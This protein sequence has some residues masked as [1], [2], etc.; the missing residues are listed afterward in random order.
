MKAGIY[1]VTLTA[2]SSGCNT[3]KTA[4]ITVPEVGSVSFTQTA[5]PYCQ[6]EPIYFTS[7]SKGNI[8][9]YHW[10]LG[11][12]KVIAQNTAATFEG[13][14]PYDLPLN[15]TVT[16]TAQD[17][18]GCNSVSSSMF[19]V[20]GNTLNNDILNPLTIQKSSLLPFCEGDSVQ[21]LSSGPVTT[22]NPPISYLWSTL[23][24]TPSIW[25]K[26][27]GNYGV[28]IRDAVNSRAYLPPI[29][30]QAYPVF[31]P[32]IYGATT[33]CAD[34][35]EKL[36]TFENPTISYTWIV[37][38]FAS[39][40]GS[41]YADY[42][43]SGSHSI[44]VEA[45]DNYTGCIDTSEVFT[46]TVRPVL[47]S[48][49]ISASAAVPYCEG[50]AITFTGYSAD[51]IAYNWNGGQSDASI[52]V[53]K[54][55]N[56]VLTITDTAGCHSKDSVTI[57]PLPDF[58]DFLFG[59]YCFPTDETNAPLL[60]GPTAN[61]YE[62]YVNGAVASTAQNFQA[63]L[64]I[65]QLVATTDA[66]CT[67]TSKV[68]EVSSYPC[69][70]CSLSLGK[71]EL[72]CE[73][74]AANGDF[75][76]HFQMDATYSGTSLT[77]YFVTPLING[78]PGGTITQTNLIGLV[79]G[80]KP[81]TGSLVI[82]Q[83]DASADVCFVVTALDAN[84][85]ICYDTI[86]A[87][88]PPAI[89]NITPD[90]TYVYD[91]QTCIT[92]FTNTSTSN[93]CTAMDSTK[94]TWNFI[95]NGVTTN[96]Q[97][98]TISLPNL[99]GSYKV[100]LNTIGYNYDNTTDCHPSLCKNVSIEA[101][102]CICTECE[103]EVTNEVFAGRTGNGCEMNI[104]F[105]I[106]NM[107]AD[108]NFIRAVSSSG[109]ISGFN[110]TFVN[111]GMGSYTLN[112]LPFNQNSSQTVCIKLFFEVDGSD[113]C[114][115]EFCVEIPPCDPDGEGR[116]SNPNPEMTEKVS[117]LDFS[118]VPNPANT[119]VNVLWQPFDQTDVITITIYS[120]QF[121]LI[122]SKQVD[123]NSGR[124]ALNVSNWSNGMYLV[125]LESKNKRMSKR[126]LVIHNH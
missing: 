108:A 78:V 65:I 54:P 63:Q 122:Y 70:S 62:W 82:N 39:T 97:G 116:K 94:T 89:C 2:S 16:L 98:N 112:I 67:D 103:M 42:L 95:R 3:K 1:T 101:V 124:L 28:K 120:S 8:V 109:Q 125:Q 114:C 79:N 121:E 25:A 86:C 100:C 44:Q 90:F 74:K 5:P 93:P 50:T 69:E 38:G 118:I 80:T 24:T 51:A 4:T 71:L 32:S 66:G 59:C 111:S 11:G 13:S 92:T 61:T 55:D 73:G 119:L 76:F 99:G 105:D 47:A 58:S 84:M 102:E 46:I 34:E 40:M 117:S 17:K 91:E 110:P 49:I 60:H 41:E 48:P 7:T 37:N 43:T 68:L 14:V 9:S 52:V 106:D 33:F 15:P 56:Y 29:N 45:Y 113:I 64:G 88:M 104:T 96:Y 115:V 36:S 87:A 23:N 83:P 21:L 35:R 12:K 6:Q 72:T 10:N 31:S 107:M 77:P 85:Q 27:S 75:I 22:S 57:N 30:V 19:T 18:I 126:M 53:N 81:L 26:R 123:N 20:N